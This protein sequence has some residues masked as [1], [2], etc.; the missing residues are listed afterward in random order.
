MSNSA[1]MPS[2]ATPPAGYRL[3][4]YGE[5]VNRGYQNYMYCWNSTGKW[6]AV[7]SMA[8][9]LGHTHTRAKTYLL[10]VRENT[11]PLHEDFGG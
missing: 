6:G 11:Q 8:S 10:A 1:D 2:G 3:V 4:E 5:V 7:G 9:I